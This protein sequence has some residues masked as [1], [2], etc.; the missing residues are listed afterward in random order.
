MRQWEEIEREVRQAADTAALRS[1]RDDVHRAFDA[2]SAE[3]GGAIEPVNRL[4]DAFIRRT[5]ALTEER[6]RTSLPGVPPVSSFAVLLF[7]SGGRREQTL[8]SD[9]DNGIVYEAAEGVESEEADAYMAQ[10]GDAFRTALEE[11]GYPPCEGNVLV[12][13]PQWRKP[14]GAWLDTMREWFAQPEFE[15]VRH[16]LIVADARPIYGDARLFDAMRDEYARLVEAHRSTMLARMAHNTLRYKVL[17]GILGN[18][19][20]EPYGEDAGGV[21]IKYGAYIPMVNAI[22]LLA[23]G[24]GANGNASTLE[25]IRTLREG[26]FVDAEEAQAWEE[27]FR[28]VLRFRAMTPYQLVDGKYGTRGILSAKSLTKEVRRELKRSLRVGAA[29]QRK[30]KRTFGTEGHR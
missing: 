22:R 3:A 12:S 5:L 6:V 10:L 13:N 2:S 7:G 1:L 23:I 4:H 21:D 25:R 24:H 14:V 26:G 8:W 17:V 19:L 18:L 29:L 27:A 15:T 30:V 11:V 16:L 9:Q 20:T 28:A